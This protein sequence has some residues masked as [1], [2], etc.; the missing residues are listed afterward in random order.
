MTEQE[1][2]ERQSYPYQRRERKGEPP[3]Y[4]RAA[5]FSGEQAAGQAY[6]QVQEAIYGGS[7][8][9]LSAYRLIIK[10]IYHVSVFRQPPPKDLQQQLE[11]ILAAGEPAELPPDVVTLLNRLAADGIA[12]SMVTY[13]E[14]YDGTLRDTNPQEA[15]AKFKRFLAGVPIL[16]FS[17]AVAETCAQL[18]HD[19]RTQGKRVNSRAL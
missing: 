7:P 6:E 18:R 11:N 13:M 12:I 19:L 9:D 17:D 1:Q 2:P 14:V 16:P 3:P 15:Q 4:L 10:K 8:N 5:R